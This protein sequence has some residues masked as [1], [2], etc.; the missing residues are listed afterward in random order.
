MARVKI[1]YHDR[2]P[3]FSIAVVISAAVL[4]WFTLM[5]WSADRPMQ[6]AQRDLAQIIFTYQCDA[7][8][9]FAGPGD[10]KSLPC[11]E[12]G[13]T[14]RAW[15]I[16]SYQCSRHGGFVYQIRYGND[17]VDGR[18]RI[19]AA[20]PLG[21]NWGDVSDHISCPQCDRALSPDLTLRAALVPD[22]PGGPGIA[23]PPIT[24]RPASGSAE[25]P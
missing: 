7:G 1:K 16:W 9:R 4:I 19:V 18:P 12:A 14:A 13:C 23:P 10:V 17:E 22:L 11:T 24:S 3:R 2:R 20:R 5:L 15:P 8:H 6:S 21:G 25:A